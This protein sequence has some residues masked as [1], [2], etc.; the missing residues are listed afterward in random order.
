MNQGG[1][2]E[3]AGFLFKHLGVGQSKDVPVPG[4][5]TFVSPKKLNK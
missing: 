4:P 2:I 5:Y 1:A 3:D